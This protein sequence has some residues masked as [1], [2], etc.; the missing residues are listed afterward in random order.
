M[1]NL[2]ETTHEPGSLRADPGVCAACAAAGP[3]CC[4]IEPGS[5]NAADIC[6]P[7]SVP[8]WERIHDF[9]KG[10]LGW[11]CYEPNTVAFRRNMDRLFPG[12]RERVRELFPSGKEHM[13][14]ATR[15]DGRCV[16][17]DA[18]GCRLPREARPLYCQLFPFWVAFDRLAT[19]GSRACL[20]LRNGKHPAG[21][22]DVFGL[23]EAWV[24]TLHGR[25]RLAWGF[26]PQSDAQDLSGAVRD[27]A[28]GS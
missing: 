8:E 2:T 5:S 9:A 22:L 13:R 12:E 11:F 27:P 3:T 28:P 10:A 14:L 7:L 16:F 4:Q 6:F 20:A 15:P 17:L 23:G 21:M 18:M 24:R 19:V 25:L 26:L 1:N